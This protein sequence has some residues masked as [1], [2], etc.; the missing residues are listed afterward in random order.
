MTRRSP[1]QS[2]EFSAVSGWWGAPQPTVRKVQIDVTPDAH[3]HEAG[4]EQ[5]RYDLNGFGGSSVVT[6]DDLSRIKSIDLAMLLLV[7][8]G[9]GSTWVNF[10]FF[11]AATRAAAGPFLDALGQPARDLRLAFALTV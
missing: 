10:N 3:A 7:R 9:I 11:H 5:G 2:M 1:G 6:Q 4:Y 8:P